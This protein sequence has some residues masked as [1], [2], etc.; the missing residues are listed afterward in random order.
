MR[1]MELY[2]TPR[3][4]Y[5]GHYLAKG[6]NGIIN[7]HNCLVKTN[8]IKFD[9]VFILFIDLVEADLLLFIKDFKYK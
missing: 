9:W 8:K 2:P 1:K 3:M 4:V 5:E 6:F 7:F